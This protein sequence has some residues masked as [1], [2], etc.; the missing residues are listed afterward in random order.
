MKNYRVIGLTGQS[1]AGKTTVCN[2][3]Q[4][5][6][7]AVINA[8]LLAKK[9]LDENQICK[10]TLSLTFGKD[11]IN[12]NNTINRQLLADKCFTNKNNT[13]LLN[14]ITHPFIIYMALQEIKRFA[15]LGKQYIVFDAPVLFESYSDVFCDTIISV[16]SSLENRTKRIINR[17]K[18]TYEQAKKRISAQYDDNFYIQRSDFVIK[19]NKDLS[20]LLENTLNVIN[21]VKQW[22]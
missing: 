17:D 4:E 11:I 6:G 19:N 13:D 22:R 1:G 9:L 14:K 15:A 3:L 10:K 2:I 8:D 12:E 16:I 18:I 21:E 5:N 20:E 7:F